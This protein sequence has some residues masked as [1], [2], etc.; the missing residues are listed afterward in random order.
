MAR[1]NGRWTFLTNHSHVLICIV[2]DPTM[3]MRDLAAEVG[4]TERAVQRIVADLSDAGYLTPERRGRRNHYHVNL[5]LPMRHPV[6]GHCL[7][8]ELLN[9]I[10]TC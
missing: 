10:Q 3:R 8:S 6:E 4:I 5:G 9:A 2:N 7:I 1:T